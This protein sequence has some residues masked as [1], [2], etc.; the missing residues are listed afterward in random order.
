M[1][2][3]RIACLR[4]DRQDLVFCQRVLP[5]DVGPGGR[6]QS[7]LG[8]LFHENYNRLGQLSSSIVCAR[9]QATYY[10]A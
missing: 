5:R 8:G 9:G 7:G 4:L 1:M 3:V 10:V 2:D 6:V